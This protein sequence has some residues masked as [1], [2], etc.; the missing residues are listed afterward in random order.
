MSQSLHEAGR[1]FSSQENEEAKTNALHCHLFDLAVNLSR[2]HKLDDILT[3]VQNVGDAFRR[4]GKFREAIAFY[5][6]YLTTA[7]Q[8]TRI[9]TALQTYE[10]RANTN[11]GHSFLGILVS[12]NCLL[13]LAFSFFFMIAEQ[14]E[15]QWP[16][17]AF[18]SDYKAYEHFE[19]A[20][21]LAYA[22]HEHLTSNAISVASSSTPPTA[23]RRCEEEQDLAQDCSSWIMDAPLNR[24][25]ALYEL[26]LLNHNLLTLHQY[27]SWVCFCR[28]ILSSSR[29]CFILIDFPE[30]LLHLKSL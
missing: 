24:G 16:G 18:F 13:H 11:L 22:L 6:Q 23:A 29:S 12:L 28:F 2:L 4:L 30:L 7:Q 1:E 10:Q 5:Q 17:D 26:G 21:T 14:A 3:S 20:T 27:A 9:Q 19:K 25:N 8:H 15:S